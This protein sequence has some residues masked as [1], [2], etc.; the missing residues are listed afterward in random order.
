MSFR[1]IFLTQIYRKLNYSQKLYNNGQFLQLP[2]HNLIPKRF[3]QNAIKCWQCGIERKNVC[4]LF[5][6]QCNFIQSPPEKDNYFKI[7]EMEEKFDIN[8]KQLTLKY[9]QMQSLLHPDKFSNK[10]V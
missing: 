3:N 4:E 10:Y 8:Q 9:R 5:C 6:E 7:F 2:K 1:A